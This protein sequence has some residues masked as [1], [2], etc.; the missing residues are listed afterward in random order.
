MPLPGAYGVGISGPRWLEDRSRLETLN[1]VADDFRQVRIQFYYPA[2]PTDQSVPYIANNEQSYELA[3][4]HLLTLG[5][6]SELDR[7]IQA[8]A[9]ENAAFAPTTDPFPVLLFSPGYGLSSQYF[10]SLIEAVVSHGY[11]VVAIDHPYV[12]GYIPMPDGSFSKPVPLNEE[13]PQTLF[14]LPIHAYLDP[15]LQD[16]Q[17]VIQT[18]ESLD[19]ADAFSGRLDLSRLGIFGH[20]AGAS[21]AIQT[22]RE[23]PRCK[24]AF[25]LDGWALPLGRVP[26]VPTV[27]LFFLLSAEEAANPIGR[28]PAA[29][30][31][32]TNRYTAIIEC[33]DHI[34]FCD[35]PYLIDQPLASRQHLVEPNDLMEVSSALI[36]AFFD[37]YVKTPRA[38]PVLAVTQ[39][40]QRGAFAITTKEVPGA[41]PTNGIHITPGAV[42]RI[43]LP[44]VIAPLERQIQEFGAPLATTTPSS[45]MP[46][47][48]ASTAAA[49]NV[50]TDTAFNPQPDLPKPDARRDSLRLDLDTQNAKPGARRDSELES[51]LGSFNTK[52]DPFDAGL[53]SS[54]PK[55]DSLNLK[56]ASSNSE[57]V[58]SIPLSE[59]RRISGFIIDAQSDIGVQAA[60][61]QIKDTFSGT[62]AAENGAYSIKIKALPATLLVSSIGYDSATWTITQSSPDTLDIRLQAAPVQLKTKEISATDPAQEIMRQV[63][64][65]KP[66]H[67]R[68]RTYK[69][70]QYGRWSVANDTSI[71]TIR[72][73]M[74]EVFWHH[75]KGLRF[76]VKARRGSANSDQADL[77]FDDHTFMDFYA[78]HF[79][80]GDR[81]STVKIPLPTHPKAFSHYRFSL[82]GQRYLNGKTIY[83][84]AFKPKS[85]INSGL[86]GRL[87]VLDE[88]FAM[89]EIELQ[90]S[91]SMAAEFT[92]QIGLQGLDLHYWQ[93][94][95]AFGDGIWL[96]VDMKNKGMLKVGLNKF[97]FDL[98]AL[99]FSGHTHLTDYQLDLD[100]P[101]TLFSATQAVRLD[102][103]WTLND[104]LF[105]P[106][107]QQVMLDSAEIWAYQNL[108]STVTLDS[109]FKATG[110]LASDFSFEK[111]KKS[112]PAHDQADSTRAKRLPAIKEEAWFNRVDG[113]HLGAT[114]EKPYKDLT[115]RLGSAYNTG[116]KRWAY[117]G[118]LRYTWGPTQSGHL[119]AAYRQGSRT[120]YDSDYYS[121]SHNNFQTL[122]G[123]NDYF[124]Y[125]WNEEVTLALGYR[126]EQAKIEFNLAFNAADHSS[127]RQRTNLDLL[128]RSRILRPNPSIA[129]GHLRSV[130][131]QTFIG[132]RYHPFKR[133]PG[134]QAQIKIEHAAKGLGSDF[135]FIRY[136]VQAL[137]R[138]PTLFKN[139]GR[140]NTLDLRLTAGFSTGQVPP[141]RLGILDT[142]ILHYNT[143]GTFKTLQGQ[144]YEGDRHLALFCEHNF[145]T[146]PFELLGL[147][148]LVKR[149]TDL[150]IHGAAG[151]TWNKSS[152]PR[153]LNFTPHSTH[154]WHREAGASLLLFKALR[155]DLTR[156]LDRPG[157]H[158]GI[159]VS[160]FFLQG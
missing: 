28:P 138:M 119:R 22:A 92:A 160:S 74:A 47:T 60:T 80:F 91:P 70:I 154:G 125:Y 55:P 142:G 7:T 120:R 110:I 94:F 135:G 134:R 23:T 5:I 122:F 95:R 141:Q 50:S 144:P 100:F 88:E 36:V 101:D 46:D 121:V 149:G 116:I 105:A 38:D 123:V 118:H 108:D 35:L 51:E 151:R 128:G 139:K 63:L 78:D 93:S 117:N 75:T 146:A 14:D 114:A 53:V 131:W 4:L 16:A 76:I 147:W 58:F 150:T 10:R 20:S 104:S 106:Y 62:I 41:A 158:F 12:S 44:P 40:Y 21:T 26:D 11:I 145:H 71:V 9:Q 64:A 112:G 130:I 113:I 90:P 8:H 140:P 39:S 65:N 132:G 66:R 126:L 32:A 34:G 115:L 45:V 30:T 72:E 153:S 3:R 155:L 83:D 156:R 111:N 59:P 29:V 89:V 25:S 99:N 52:P 18:L 107:P 48:L 85:R 69:A 82:Q 49:Q 157:W 133:Q 98:P 136:D 87:S 124:D 137:W 148:S 97:A 6:Q 15:L 109:R 79:D 42:H 33:T 127:L 2:T 73:D 96:P 103:P 159:G 61:L 102:T 67:R 152:L 143:F 43:T 13:D 19:P 1:A 86:S 24:A 57:P 54:N 81:N 27:P 129:P 17:F 77:V 37:R 56:S 84:I 31:G 68:I